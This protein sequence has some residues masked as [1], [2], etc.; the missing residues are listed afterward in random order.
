MTRRI[1]V[2]LLMLVCVLL[3]SCTKEKELVMGEM[4]TYRG[5]GDGEIIISVFWPPMKGY[6]T[7]EQ[8]DLLVEA[9]IDLL[10]WGTDPIFT[11][12]ETLENTLRLCKDKGIKITICDKDFINLPA[13][14]DEEI[15]ELVRRYKDHDSVVGYYVLDEPRNANPFGR[16]ARI[17]VEEHPGCITQLNM[18]P[19]FALEDPRGHAEDWINSVGAENLRYLSFDQYPFD[20]QE[21]SVPQMFPNFKLIWETGLKYNVDTALY[22][23]SIG[24][25]GG[26]R[27]PTVAET[28][29]HTSAALAYGFKNLKYF[30][31]FT[32]TERSE[33]FTEAIVTPDGKKGKT[34]DGIARINKDIKK[35]SKI[36][37][38]VDALEIYHN[39]RQDLETTM[40]EKGWHVEAVDDKDFIVS[41]MKDRFDG[42]NYIMIV[43]KNFKDDEKITLKLNGIDKLYDVT[44]GKAMEAKINK[45]RIK[46]EIAAGGFRLYA[47]EEGVDLT[48]PYKDDDEKNLAY[49]KPVFAT[50]SLGEGGYYVRNA[51]DGIRIPSQ[52]SKGWRY[53]GDADSE[54][55]F[56]VDLKRKV[57]INRIDL[58]P[59]EDDRE[60]FL[61]TYTILCSDDKKEWEEIVKVEDENTIPSHIFDTVS[62][63]YVKIRMDGT[64]FV[65]G[66]HVVEIGEIEIYNDDGSI[67]PYELFKAKE[68]NMTK[69]HNVAL[70]KNVLVSSSYENELVGFTKMHLTDGI[71][72]HNSKHSGWSSEHELHMDDPYA[73]EWVVVEL[74]DVYNIDA[75]CLYPAHNGAYFPK[76]LEVQ[77]STNGADWDVVH[78]YEGSGK[79]DKRPRVFVFDK[80]DASFVRIVSKEM[81]KMTYATTGYLFQLAEFEV[82]KSDRNV[83]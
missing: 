34:F 53:E 44:S 20:L 11:D 61:K 2:I 27:R 15:R 68:K 26:F 17:M 78:F 52:G 65:D 35:V 6:A 5:Y 69:E 10:E 57:D 46:C 73:E 62:A 79:E 14:S 63:R 42:R 60:L 21:G 9:G 75:V 72:E 31:W 81:M 3:T 59:V 8:Y 55:Y 18:L 48:K 12:E 22:I 33:E 37:G 80:V 38:R 82:Y 77:V 40:L 28:R 83:G 66:K 51:V 70:G 71:T 45:G 19:A 67:M 23:Q 7:E 29:Y 1:L 13:K 32:P 58:Y 43:N 36:L 16:V 4:D 64:A 49:N 47:L 41:L 24:V 39:G 30:T 74:G 54:I 76:K 56:M 25:I 50:S